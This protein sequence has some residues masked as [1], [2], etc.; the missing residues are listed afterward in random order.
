[1][2]T[3]NFEAH[4]GRG[5]LEQIAREWAELADSIPGVRFNQLPGWYRAYLASGRCDPATVWFVTARG[6]TRELV[7][8]FPLQWHGRRIIWLGARV[9]G[10]INDNEL[11]LS[12]FT[13]AQTSANA[14]LIH[15]L[16][17][18]LRR[19]RI[20]RWDQLRLVK[21][22]ANSAF[23]FAAQ[24]RLPSMTIAATYDRSAYLDTSGTY[25]QATRAM[26]PKF[27]SNLRRRIRLAENEAPLRFESYQRPGQVEA[28]FQ[29]FLEV[30]AS[31]WKGPSGTGSAIDC[32]P[33]MLAFYAELVRE[34][35]PRNQCVINVL[36]HG[37]QAIAGQFGLRIGRTLYILKVG[38]RRSHAIFAPGIVLSS[39]T[40][41]QAS[42]DPE[43]EV[44]SLVND[45][46]WAASFRPMAAEV[47][48][49]RM[50]NWT[51]RGLLLHLGLLLWHKWKSRLAPTMAHS[52]AADTTADL[53][54]KGPRLAK[55]GHSMG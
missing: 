23:A 43:I 44:L 3:L 4:Q 40:I 25:E 9:L 37:K 47:R 46:P 32:C 11:Q 48:L 29:L 22:P 54:T 35:A 13:F 36:W 16:T 17:G 45:P 31:G 38:Y 2:P 12:D 34:F 51:P 10:T 24:A 6:A 15:E 21:I 41:R 30:E 19:Q 20:L 14:G 42:A 39:M 27:R 1:M 26:T 55:D 49:Y 50:P 28:G 7:G 5:G 53:P 8:V 18:W 52:V 33:Q